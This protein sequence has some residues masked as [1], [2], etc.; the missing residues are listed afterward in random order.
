MPRIPTLNRMYI[1]PA[2]DYNAGGTEKVISQALGLVSEISGK[3]NNLQD[4]SSMQ[5]SVSEAKNNLYNTFNEYK[6]KYSDDPQEFN[7][8]IFEYKNTLIQDTI[9]NSNVSIKNKNKF[10]ELLNNNLKSFDTQI[11]N[12][13][14]Q[15]QANK[16]DRDISNSIQV[17]QNT[18]YLHGKN[19]D[20]D[21]F[22]QDLSKELAN[23][24]SIG[25]TTYSVN[26]LN[27]K[28]INTK[29]DNAKNYIEGLIVS[30]TPLARMQ[31]ED[32][33][34]TNL[35]DQ[36]DIDGYLQ[37]INKIEDFQ[38]D[39]ENKQIDEITKEKLTSNMLQY[40][41]IIDNFNLKTEGGQKNKISNLDYKESFDKLAQANLILQEAKQNN[42]SNEKYIKEQSKLYNIVYNNFFNETINK[43]NK[44]EKN[45][46]LFSSKNV[47]SVVVDYLNN[48]FNS[49]EKDEKAM[50]Y[51]DLGSMLK[52]SNIDFT[53]TQP[54]DI[55]QIK[56]IID[57]KFR[58]LYNIPEKE[59]IEDYLLINKINNQTK[60]NN[61]V[62]EQFQN[63]DPFNIL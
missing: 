19:G 31:L 58:E 63:N 22:V 48:H 9:K 32:G 59:N 28:L 34:F 46:D 25:K 62:I 52:Q 3:I 17:S 47:N 27:K 40:Q 44:I 7:K 29:I 53:S 23:L 14:N 13:T 24:E 21:L 18:S 4:V 45:S 50:F 38:K 39:I 5:N 57:T 42:L 51:L 41:T 49:F 33:R 30:N 60:Y 55:S 37:Q 36:K 43:K 8:Q 61:K 10:S 15:L 26:T 54:Q 12:T 16:I 11:F 6:I 20:Y 1:A 35:L 2:K 56:R